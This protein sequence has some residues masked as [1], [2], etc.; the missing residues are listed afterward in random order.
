MMGWIVTC[1]L[2]IITNIFCPQIFPNYNSL[3]IGVI[4][5]ALICIDIFLGVFK[6]LNYSFVNAIE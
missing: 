5:S 4:A 3:T 1:T 2:C 6:G